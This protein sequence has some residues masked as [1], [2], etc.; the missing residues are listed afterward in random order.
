MNAFLVNVAAGLITVWDKELAERKG[1]RIPEDGL[2]DLVLYGGWGGSVLAQCLRWHK[3]N[4]NAFLLK[5]AK[6][7]LLHYAFAII[8]L[9]AMHRNTEQDNS[10]VIIAYHALA[11]ILALLQWIVVKFR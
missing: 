8:M 4:S 9:V 6:S 1:F 2:H 11:G 5:N 3:I 7:A 10:R